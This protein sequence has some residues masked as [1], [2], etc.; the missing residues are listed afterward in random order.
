MTSKVSCARCG[1][2]DWEHATGCLF[3]GTGTAV[4]VDVSGLTLHF[5]AEMVINRLD[6]M[7]EGGRGLTRD[8][9]ML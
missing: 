1:Q 4:S 2:Y 9:E 3:A 6:D 5:P 8:S 7:E